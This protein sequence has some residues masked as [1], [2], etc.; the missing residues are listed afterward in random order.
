M[1]QCSAVCCLRKCFYVNFRWKYIQVFI[2][3][4]HLLFKARF[5]LRYQIGSQCGWIFS[6]AFIILT[7]GFLRYISSR[8]QIELY[9]LVT[10]KVQSLSY[11]LWIFPP[12]FIA[13]NILF[14]TIAESENNSCKIK[15]KICCHFLVLSWLFFCINLIKK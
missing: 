6:V 15:Q 13:K 10:C 7:S 3:H 12:F 5:K 8:R 11:E 14:I 4:K 9:I 1:D 2:L